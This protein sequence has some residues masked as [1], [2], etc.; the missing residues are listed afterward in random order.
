MKDKLDY[1][2]ANNFVTFDDYRK[3]FIAWDETQARELG[4]FLTWDAALDCVL[5]YAKS[6]EDDRY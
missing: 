3:M 5:E 2:W 6:I 4:E 1:S